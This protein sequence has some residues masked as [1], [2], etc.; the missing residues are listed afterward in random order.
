MFS[1]SFLRATITDFHL[2]PQIASL[3]NIKVKF[4]H[5]TGSF[6]FNPPLIDISLSI[7]NLKQDQHCNIYIIHNNLAIGVAYTSLETLLH[8]SQVELNLKIK[9]YPEEN[10]Y[11]DRNTSQ[12]NEIGHLKLKILI[13]ETKIEEFK[14]F[15]YSNE[16]LEISENALEDVINVIKD[17]KL[18]KKPKNESFG[19]NANYLLDHE[20]DS[21]KIKNI[22]S[23]AIGINEKLKV[24]EILKLE[25]DNLQC[26]LDLEAQEK[27]SLTEIISKNL[28]EFTENYKNLD[29]CLEV[30]AKKLTKSRI[31]LD[32]SKAK[33]RNLLNEN[34][35]LTIEID[36]LKA[37]IFKLS[38]EK[39]LHSSMEL[40]IKELQ[41]SIQTKEE[42]TNSLKTEMEKI[43]SGHFYNLSQQ[44][45]YIDQLLQE[46]SEHCNN[47][48]ILKQDH[49]ELLQKYEILGKHCEELETEQLINN[50]ALKCLD[51]IESRSIKFQKSWEQS[52][53]ENGKLKALLEKSDNRFKD[54]INEY[55]KERLNL[56]KLNKQLISEN[57]KIEQSMNVIKEKMTK[58]EAELIKF[59]SQNLP[60]R[61][62]QK[63]I[64]YYKSQIG[65]FRKVSDKYSKFESELSSQI[66]TFSDS[67]LDL[68]SRNLELQRSQGRLL[69]RYR[70]KAEEIPTLRE[71]ISELQKG[72]DLYIP[73]PGDLIDN[74]LAN[75]I[76]T[77]TE[78]LEV[79]FVRV[80]HGM[81]LYGTKKVGIRIENSGIVSNL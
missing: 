64:D 80:Q 43:A 70:E 52:L 78:K 23:L 4:S 46:N 2:S 66:S 14:E 21:N 71:M 34:N 7:R 28:K 55:Q 61:D 79:P 47:Y 9:K 32:E 57:S 19:F 39:K 74:Y 24:L 77:R 50:A 54:C 51:D 73:V 5:S 68:S 67:F 11:F 62:Y 40:L 3:E 6:I 30:S 20:L 17:C 81:Y 53:E 45:E 1:I 38:E 59:R 48:L 29:V 49:S 27:K 10:N 16:L 41:I 36:S 18:E 76:N 22:K 25:C 26:K 37:E 42:C 60:N 8:E 12:G 15:S 72:R 58:S 44:Q 69:K 33:E 56:N 65:T 35:K 63:F 75:Y 13:E 31:E